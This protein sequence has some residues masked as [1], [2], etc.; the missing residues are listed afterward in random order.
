MIGILELLKKLHEVGDIYSVK[1]YQRVIQTTRENASHFKTVMIT[2]NDFLSFDE[3]L[4]I[5]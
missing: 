1:K 5:I 2:N 4:I 3:V